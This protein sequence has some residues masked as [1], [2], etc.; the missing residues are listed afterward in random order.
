MVHFNPSLTKC[1][2]IVNLINLFK[3]KCKVK[4]SNLSKELTNDFE[5]I[6]NFSNN[7]KQ[8]LLLFDG[9]CEEILNSKQFL[10]TATTGRHREMNAIYVKRNLF[11]QSELGRD[12]EVQNTHS[13]VQ[14]TDR[15]STNQYIKS[16]TRFRV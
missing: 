12:T 5:L 4:T 16:T 2:I 10:K 11:H 7:G 8:H 13:L 15:C 9:S 3:N 6:E 1:S 14:V